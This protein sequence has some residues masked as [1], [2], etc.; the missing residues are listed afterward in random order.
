MKRIYIKLGIWHLGGREK[1]KRGFFV[2][3]GAL[4]RPLL[5]FPADA[6]G[7]KVLKRL[8]KKNW[9]GEKEDLEEEDENK[10]V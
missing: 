10:K 5:A 4:P 1:Q 3:L 2:I 7:G 9:G 8:G 6:V